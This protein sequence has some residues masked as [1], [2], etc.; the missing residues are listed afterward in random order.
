MDNRWSQ[1]WRNQYDLVARQLWNDMEE[2]VWRD[3]RIFSGLEPPSPDAE[4]DVEFLNDEE[5]EDIG[6][7]GDLGDE[8]P[9]CAI[10]RLV[11]SV[12]RH[13]LSMAFL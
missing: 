10:P 5:M 8:V 11:S 12:G 2:R 9:L 1:A 6:D 4:D 3:S 13:G 7:L